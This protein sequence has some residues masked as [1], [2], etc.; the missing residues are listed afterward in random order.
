MKLV[1]DI[2]E[3]DYND[4]VNY[5]GSY[6]FGYQIKCGKPLDQVL[7]KIRTEIETLNP[8]DYVSMSSYEGHRGAEDM[9]DD[10]LQIIDKHI[11]KEW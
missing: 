5:K 11:G 1:I 10:V 9:K 8:V 2:D 4:V 7:D 6:D 3:E